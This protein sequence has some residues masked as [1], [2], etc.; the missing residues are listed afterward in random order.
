MKTGTPLKRKTQL[1]AKKG[2]Q[3]TY[4]PLASRTTFKRSNW[5]KKMPDSDQAFLDRIFSRYIRKSSAD[6]AGLVSCCTCGIVRHWQQMQAGHFMDRQH[7]STRYNE[8]NVYP[9]CEDC[10]C[11]REKEEMLA[12]YVVFLG[13][14]IAM[15]LKKLSEEIIH[16]FPYKE[17]IA[18]YE[19]KLSR[20]EGNCIEF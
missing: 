4:S 1:I 19:E 8:H 14:D 3:K 9:Q 6:F 5:A 16:S 12:A 10:N 18:E 11:F 13:T 20:L 2:F 15:R 17:K 7:I